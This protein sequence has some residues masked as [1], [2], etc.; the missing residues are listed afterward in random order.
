MI[1]SPRADYRFLYRL[2]HSAFGKKI[3]HLPEEYD[4]ILSVFRRSGGSWVSIF[5]GDPDHV[6][7]LKRVVRVAYKNKHVS[8]VVEW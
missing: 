5:N 4:R 8:R 3:Q 1:G 7:L 6:K 2:L